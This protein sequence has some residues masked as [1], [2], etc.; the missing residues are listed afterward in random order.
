MH[1]G[2]ERDEERQRIK[3]ERQADFELQR[4]LEAEY[5]KLQ[6]VP[7]GQ[8]N[9]PNNRSVGQGSWY[10]NVVGQCFLRYK[11]EAFV[12]DFFERHFFLSFLLWASRPKGKGRLLCL[13]ILLTETRRTFRV[14]MNMYITL[15]SACI[16]T[17][18]VALEIKPTSWYELRLFQFSVLVLVQFTCYTPPLLKTIFRI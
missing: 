1:A 6:H 12:L 15:D 8:Q 14:D 5:R 2:V 17:R 9:D 13:E 11:K 16:I 4:R 18:G 10:M 7:E 3:R